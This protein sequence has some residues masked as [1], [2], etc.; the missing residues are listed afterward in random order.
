ML[1]GPRQFNLFLGSICRVADEISVIMQQ[2]IIDKPIAW[3]V[4]R[5]SSTKKLLVLYGGSHAN[6]HIVGK[7]WLILIILFAQ[8][9]TKVINISR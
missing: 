3:N 1:I 8:C 9:A 2:F 4:K 5:Y 7:R 6:A